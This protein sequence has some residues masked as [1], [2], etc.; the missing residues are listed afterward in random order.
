MY[1]CLSAITATEGHRDKLCL[2]LVHTEEEPKLNTRF[3]TTLQVIAETGSLA[4]AARKLNL[5]P[6][7]ISEQIRAL[8]REFGVVLLSRRGRIMHLT[9]AGQAVVT[10]AAEVLSRVADLHQIARLETLSGPLRVGVISSAMITLLPGV[11][12]RMGERYAGIALSILPGTSP[13]L[14]RMLELGQI[15]CAVMVLPPFSLPK[16]LSWQPL[17]EHPLVLVGTPEMASGSL[18]DVL[19]SRPFIRIDRQAWTGQIVDAFLRA[20]ELRVNTVVEMDGLEIIAMLAAQGLGVALMP[21]WGFRHET[22]IRVPVRNPAYNRIT[23]LLGRGGPRQ[24]LIDAFASSFPPSPEGAVDI[25]ALTTCA[26]AA[27]E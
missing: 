21:D 3:L 15:D 16:T 22:L 1:G 7:S 20:R 25:M 8:E 23:G 18:E 13:Q 4:A 19:Q 12:K 5:A 27:A 14:Y 9:P 2:F 24:R 26:A 17:R 10:A 11:L 6:N